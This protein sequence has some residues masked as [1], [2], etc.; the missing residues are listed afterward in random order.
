MGAAIIAPEP[1]ETFAERYVVE[2]LLGR[3]G[4][5]V[6]FAAR[7]PVLEQTVAIKLL[8]D[9]IAA[10]P[11][12]RRRFINEAKASAKI[13][14]EHVVRVLDVSTL[15]S[16]QPYIVMEHLEGVDLGRL[17]KQ[18]GPLPPSQAVDY[19]LQALTG[20]AA[21][22]LHGII[23]RDL[24]PGNL[25][26]ADRRDRSRIIKVL[27]FGI[28]KV[29]DGGSETTTDALLGSPAYMSPEQARSTKLVDARTDI[30]SLGVVL[31]ELLQGKRPFRGAS[32]GQVIV[33]VLEGEPEP[34]DDKVSPELQAV[35]MRC[36]EKEPGKRYPTAL[37]LAR[38]LRPFAPPSS[39]ALVERIEAMSDDAATTLATGPKEPKEPKEPREP[40]EAVVRTMKEAPAIS[41]RRSVVLGGVVGTIVTGVLAATAFVF[42]IRPQPP[43]PAPAATP[44][45]TTPAAEPLQAPPAPAAQPELATSSAPPASVT[46]APRPVARAPVASAK[47][48]A[49][50]TD[51]ITRTR[52][53]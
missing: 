1:G 7:H 2:R 38:A 11:D 49:G 3:G 14:H 32:S 50:A 36:L 13:D 6:V 53:E 29:S 31:Y 43:V 47:P 18:G 15:P 33:A 12:H 28:S 8:Q 21:A 35:V 4:M 52:K 30:W 9:D 48:D 51:A 46:I 45:M 26:R 44:T 10:D 16:G 20:I 41:T 37:E 17:L 39:A 22:H 23:H 42:V 34:L 25:F 19:V 40:E 5:G 24:K 27:D